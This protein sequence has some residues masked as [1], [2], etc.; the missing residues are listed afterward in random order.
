MRL[1]KRGILR[2][3]FINQ[4]VKGF[5]Q[6]FFKLYHLNWFQLTE[7][8]LSNSTRPF[9]I[10]SENIEDGQEKLTKFFIGFANDLNS[11]AV[12]KGFVSPF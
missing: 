7:N 5:R 6:G 12:G 11:H 2:L 4:G 1:V 10:I 8:P 3:F 9:I